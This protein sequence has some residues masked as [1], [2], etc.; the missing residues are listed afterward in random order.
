MKKITSARYP[1]RVS[2]IMSGRYFWRPG[3]G[4]AGGGG[5]LRDTR[6]MGSARRLC[7]RGS[8]TGW[9]A[10]RASVGALLEWRFP[11]ERR[12]RDDQGNTQ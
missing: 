9:G 12:Y 10:M 5:H 4:G 11:D 8:G 2:S 7:A 1:Y 6:G 3:G